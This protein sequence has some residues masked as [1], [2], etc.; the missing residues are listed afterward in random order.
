MLC[1]RPADKLALYT[2]GCPYVGNRAFLD[3]WESKVPEQ[4][5]TFNEHDTVPTVPRST[6]FKQTARG[7]CLMEHPRKGDAFAAAPL[8]DERAAFFCDMPA[9]T[10]GGGLRITDEVRLRSSGL[11]LGTFRWK[12]S[13]FVRTILL[14]A[15][16]GTW[17]THFK[18][19]VRAH[20][21]DSH[22][23]FRHIHA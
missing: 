16:P 18:R 12:Y 20:Q 15:P 8:H 11:Q 5:R 1:R 14:D 9:V 3:A 4:W 6:G 13:R 23:T 7:V 17:S 2:Y 22:P 19:H 10:L 21:A